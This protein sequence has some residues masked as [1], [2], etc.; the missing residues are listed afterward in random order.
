MGL[1]LAPEALCPS[2][3]NAALPPKG[4]PKAP[5]ASFLP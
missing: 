2:H 3:S 1:H 5:M 4:L